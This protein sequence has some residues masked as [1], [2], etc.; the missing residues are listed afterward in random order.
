MYHSIYFGEKNTWD[1]WHLIPRSRPVVN[2]PKVKTH[3]VEIPGG[4]GVLDLTEALAGRPLYQNR[5]GSFE[6]YVEN[7]FKDW[8]VLYSEILDYLH[9]RKMLMELEDDPGSYFSGRFS[10]NAWKSEEQRSIIAIDYDVAPYKQDGLNTDDKWLWDTFNFT[11]GVIRHYKNLP[12]H[13]T[14]EMIVIGNGSPVS[15]SITASAEGM[16]V[17]FNGQTYALNK[18]VNRIREIVIQNGENR[19]TFTGYGEITIGRSGGML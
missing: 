12:V 5:T 19:L 16:S 17:A 8:A 7:G 6:F 13:G 1:D 3:T 10:V 2:P 4:D 14:L 18:G 9:G 15:P 11:T